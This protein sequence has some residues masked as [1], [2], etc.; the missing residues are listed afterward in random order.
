VNITDCYNACGAFNFTALTQDGLVK[1]RRSK[2]DKK[3]YL[4]DVQ[5]GPWVEGKSKVTFYGQCNDRHELTGVGREVW[6]TK[7][8]RA[9]I[10]EGMFVNG[11]L[12]GF[13]RELIVC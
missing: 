7:F 13:G 3:P 1:P 11:E 6:V 10:R 2:E 8:G 4:L 5:P 12:N 9:Q